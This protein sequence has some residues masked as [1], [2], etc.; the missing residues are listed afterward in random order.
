MTVRWTLVVALMV[1][2][3]L[4][5][6][7]QPF[8]AV[9]Q[10]ARQAVARGDFDGLVRSSPGVQ[11]RLPGLEPSSALGPAQAAAALRGAFRR[12]ETAE[13]TVESF[14]EVG[15][16]RGYVELRREFRASGSPE[17]RVQRILLSY[18]LVDGRWKVVEA[19]V[20]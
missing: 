20:N 10:Q 15:P 14:R 19:R 1:A 6:A 8:S 13:V 16:G 17:R 7:Q 3:A 11:L 5:G 4:A 12:G 2:P 9:A 18:R